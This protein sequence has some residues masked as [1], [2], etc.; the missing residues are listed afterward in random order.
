MKIG[1]PCL[2]WSLDCTPN[3]TF[4]LRNYS[5]E[6]LIKK[7]EY[8]LKCLKRI[9]E[10]NRKHNLLF[11]RLGSGLIP[12]GSH[13]ILEF[14][15]K[16]EFKKDFDELGKF[17]KDNNFR[18]SMHPDQFVVINSKSEKI[19]KKSIAELQYHCDVLDAFGLDETAKVQI[20]V[21]GVYGDKKESMK[22][23]IEVYK[24]LPKNILK[25]LAIE[26]D[27]K[28]YTIKDC[29]EINKK[30][31]IPIIADSFHHECN[32]EGKNFREMFEK[33]VKTWKKKDGVPMLD[34][35]SQRKN[36]R[37]GNHVQHID[38]KKF[39]AFLKETKGLDF[40][41]ML[42]IKDKEKSALKAVKL[43]SQ[44]F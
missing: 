19:V 34:Y 35:S 44:I 43:I 1:Y 27:D 3:S 10:Y 17:M 36:A 14:D 4:R 11:L 18:I 32:N 23:F 21:G 24:K 13:E 42:E 40:D 7:I 9:L 41:I 20:H 12:F 15:W 5:E 8:N 37:K 33:I 2:N 38:V 30:T 16:K 29:L 6:M 28:S 26:N 22:R 31:K 25:R 39:K